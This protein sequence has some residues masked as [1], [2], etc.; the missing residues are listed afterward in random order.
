MNLPGS[1]CPSFTLLQRLLLPSWLHAVTVCPCHFLPDTPS[2]PSL[3]HTVIQQA[4]RKC[5]D[6]QPT[7]NLPPYNRVMFWHR[8]IHLQIVNISD[9]ARLEKYKIAC[10]KCAII[11]AFKQMPRLNLNNFYRHEFFAYHFLLHLYLT[12]IFP[13]AT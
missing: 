11:S 4:F 10:K 5:T 6:P 3:P 13:P 2:S 1:Y 12:P 8:G 7:Q 9:N